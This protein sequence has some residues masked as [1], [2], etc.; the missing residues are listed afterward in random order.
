MVLG[1]TDE[2]LPPWSEL[3]EHKPTL[4]NGG[5][6]SADQAELARN[7]QAATNAANLG[8]AGTLF[9]ISWRAVKPATFA[10]GLEA[11]YP[12]NSPNESICRG[13]PILPEPGTVNSGLRHHWEGVVP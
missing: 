13:T 5:S 8:M 9:D 1:A 4:V 12:T 2:M 6:G 3:P 7:T 10:D 11:V